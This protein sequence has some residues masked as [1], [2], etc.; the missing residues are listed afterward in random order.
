M[1]KLFELP[2]INAA[3]LAMEDVILASDNF[4]NPGD[5]DQDIV[6]DNPSGGNSDWI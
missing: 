5:I 6:V 3:E 2:E 4:A 1:K